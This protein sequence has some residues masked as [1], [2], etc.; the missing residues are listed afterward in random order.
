MLQTSLLTGVKRSWRLQLTSIFK[1]VIEGHGIL[2][3]MCVT[4]LFNG[5]GDP[6]VRQQAVMEW[7]III[8]AIAT[9]LS[10]LLYN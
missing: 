10:S 4:S 9:V 7:K 5:V 3:R 2:L 1:D 8:M 6:Y